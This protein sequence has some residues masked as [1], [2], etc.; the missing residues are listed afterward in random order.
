MQ[1]ALKKNSALPD[2]RALF[3]EATRVLDFQAY[4]QRLVQ[5]YNL[6]M[7]AVEYFLRLVSLSDKGKGF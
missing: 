1:L 6:A 7:V 3:T 2:D 5:Q 4:E